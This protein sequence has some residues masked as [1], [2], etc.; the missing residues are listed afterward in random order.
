MTTPF[1][2]SATS[3]TGQP[4]SEGV[5]DGVVDGSP[6]LDGESPTSTTPEVLLHQ[7]QLRVSTQRVGVERMRISK[8]I[9]T[10]TRTIEVPVRLEQLVITREP[11]GD[12]DAVTTAGSDAMSD[13][14]S[15]ALLDAGP[16]GGGGDLV[17]V[18]D[19]EVP[20]FTMRVVAVERVAISKRTVTG[21][22]AITADL[23]AEAADVTTLDVSP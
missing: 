14:M 23:S 15:D 22:Q 7:E 11:F 19:E 17:I 16:V 1:E 5:R 21:E 3:A 9:V 10:T 8:R 12:Q 4:L 6:G 18:L 13:A 20:E 2:T